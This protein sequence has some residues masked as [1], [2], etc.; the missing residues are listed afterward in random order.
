MIARA[1]LLGLAAL[2]LTLASARVVT[3]G[4]EVAQY[5]GEG[6]V[7]EMFRPRELGGWPAP[8]L[9][10]STATSVPHRIGLEDDFRLGPFVATYAFWLLAVLALARMLRR[11]G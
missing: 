10:D 1:M 5:G 8:Y 11:H 6:T 2:G 9:A 7:G 4:D 3:T